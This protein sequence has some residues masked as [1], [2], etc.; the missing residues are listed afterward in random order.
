M[1]RPDTDVFLISANLADE[2]LR[3]RTVVIIDVLRASSTITTALQN[4]A[5]DVVAVAD[6]A[7][8]SRIA[9]YMDPS[10]FLLGGERHADKIE[11]YHLGNSPLEYTREVVEGRT[12]LFSTT[13]GTNA[14]TRTAAAKTLVVGCFLNARRVA[15][16]V[17]ERGLDVLLVC[18]GSHDRVALEDV[19]CAGLLLDL[20]WEGT[21]PGH[22]SD[23]ARIAFSQYHHN[24]DA[25]D[26]AILQTTHAQRL[27]A[28]GYGAD[29]DYCLQIDAVPALPLYREN[30]LI[31]LGDV[32]NKATA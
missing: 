12:V 26:A 2:D 22:A 20:L 30:R 7:E 14:I 15:G 9:S 25:L 10:T 24:R 21:P 8:A 23:T 18:A 11:G 13:N 27:Q 16:F 19:L 4:G 31:L 29:I 3:E 28:K 17:E 6:M 5:R 32:R 1:P